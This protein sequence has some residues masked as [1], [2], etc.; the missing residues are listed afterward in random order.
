MNEMDN[1]QLFEKTT[2]NAAVLQLSNLPELNHPEITDENSLL[3]NEEKSEEALYGIKPP[4]VELT[5]YIP[6]KNHHLLINYF[7]KLLVM[8]LTLR[9]YSYN[10]EDKYIA[11]KKSVYD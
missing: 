11:I 8:M 5:E 9:E 2:P 1:F 3:L 4:W 6:L 10:G 7:C